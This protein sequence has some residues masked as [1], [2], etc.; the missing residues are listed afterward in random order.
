MVY[1]ERE[2]REMVVVEGWGG[3]SGQLGASVY[4]EHLTE[5]LNSLIYRAGAKV[6]GHS[7]LRGRFQC[8]SLQ[9]PKY[10]RRGGGGGAARLSQQSTSIINN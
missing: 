3:S 10:T 5:W 1:E 2:E 6:N 4:K 8:T 7:R 9:R